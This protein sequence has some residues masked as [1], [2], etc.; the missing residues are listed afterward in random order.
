MKTLEIINR[1]Y[2]DDV[3]EWNENTDRYQ[4]TF[5]YVKTLREKNP[6]RN[7]RELKDQIKKTSLRVYNFIASHSNTANRQVVSFLLNKTENG[8]KFLKEVLT[9]QMEAEME[10]AY[11]DLVVR[12][13]I[14]AVDGKEGDR[15]TFRLNAI[16]IETEM[17]IEDSPNY[18]GFNICYMGAYPWSLFNMVRQYEG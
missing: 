15:D 11:N 17:L 12:P 6:Y 8:R 1:T 5:A 13:V 2:N 18:F 7:D 14:N 10:Y 16:S 3:L 4:L 9:C